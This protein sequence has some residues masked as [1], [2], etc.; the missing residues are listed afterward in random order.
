MK[1]DLRD[2]MEVSDD[3]AAGTYRLTY[4]TKIGDI[5]YV[6]DY[7]QKKGTTGGATPK[8]DLDRILQRLKKAREKHA[9]RTRR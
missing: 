8:V 9:A 6:L 2:V 7:F 3:D 5:V 4:T 1:G